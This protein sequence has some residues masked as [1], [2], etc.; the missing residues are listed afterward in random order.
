MT[1]Q[2]VVEDTVFVT[3]RV[4][5][6]KR[7]DFYDFRLGPPYDVQETLIPNEAAWQVPTQTLKPKPISSKPTV[8]QFLCS[9][10]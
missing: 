3:D 1:E 2:V 4:Q 5:L 6:W 10:Y 9:Q 7:N 8:S